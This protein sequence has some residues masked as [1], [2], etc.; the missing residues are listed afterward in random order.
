MALNLKEVLIRRVKEMSELD[1][2]D[3]LEKRYD[4]FRKIG[5]FVEKN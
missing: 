2:D 3:L 1:G 4:R 5:E